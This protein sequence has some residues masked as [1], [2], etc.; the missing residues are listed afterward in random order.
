MNSNN[1]NTS[2]PF[3]AKI[4]NNHPMGTPQKT[5][6]TFSEEI[7]ENRHMNDKFIT[8]E[9]QNND[10]LTHPSTSNQSS[11]DGQTSLNKKRGMM[12][13]ADTFLNPLKNYINRK[14]DAHRKQ[15]DA[16]EVSNDCPS[17]QPQFS[18]YTSFLL[19]T[20]YRITIQRV[21]CSEMVVVKS[22]WFYVMKKR[23]KG[24]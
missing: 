24:S 22:I 5:G 15:S 19:F 23:K 7:Y 12:K 6:V 4:I 10:K 21:L 20:Q 18:L 1:S 17:S 2:D 8:E 14:I 3:G 11:A 9:R 16:S 13:R